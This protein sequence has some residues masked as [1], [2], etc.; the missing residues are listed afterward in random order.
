MLSHRRSTTV[1]VETCPL[2]T[3]NMLVVIES[4]CLPTIYTMFIT[5]CECFFITKV[6]QV[7]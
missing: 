7:L 3:L 1:S 6:Q 2:E 5:K 4:S